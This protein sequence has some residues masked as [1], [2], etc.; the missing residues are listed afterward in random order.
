MVWCG[1]SKPSMNWPKARGGG[2]AARPPPPPP[3]RPTSGTTLSSLAAASST[4]GSYLRWRRHSSTMAVPFLMASTCMHAQLRMYAS[5][6]RRQVRACG[7]SGAACRSGPALALSIHAA[8]GGLC[9]HGAHAQVQV[10]PRSTR[11]AWPRCSCRSR[12]RSRSLPPP[13]KRLALQR[14]PGS[15]AR[16]SGWGAPYNLPRPA[17]APS[18]CTLPAPLG[19]V[20]SACSRVAAHAFRAL[21]ARYAA[22]MQAWCAATG[23]EIKRLGLWKLPTVLNQNDD[24]SSCR[25]KPLTRLSGCV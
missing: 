4:A 1:R 23:L 9:A 2:G 5:K 19:P 21:N 3:A 8:G 17:S 7:L 16:A 18:S 22:N 24:Q 10:L 6:H 25:S 13:A 11:T 12:T 15:H 14:T 20:A